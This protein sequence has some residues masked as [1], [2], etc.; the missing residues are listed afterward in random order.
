MGDTQA[1]ITIIKESCVCD[2][3]E[4][5]S[6]EIIDIRGVTD[7]LAESLGTIDAAFIYENHFIPQTLHVVPNSF[8]IGADGII[9]KDILKNYRC[10]ISY[11]NRLLTV[12]IDN[13]SIDIQLNDGPDSDSIIIPA[14]CEVAR[15]TKL[16]DCGEEARFVDAQQ[17]ADGVIIAKTIIDTRNPIARIINTTS[18]VQILKLKAID[19]E[20]LDDYNIYT[21]DEVQ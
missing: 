8:N 14:R 7:G 12:T 1:D 3:S 19:T 9:G 13:E 21:I 5:N 15:Q 2:L 11:E 17:I 10:N 6:D 18:Q 20:S 4:V 16:K